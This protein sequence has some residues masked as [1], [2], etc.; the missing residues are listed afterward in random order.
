VAQEVVKHAFLENPQLVALILTKDVKK[1]NSWMAFLMSCQLKP[2]T[3]GRR[4]EG[5]KERLKEMDTHLRQKLLADEFFVEDEKTKAPHRRARVQ[6]LEEIEGWLQE[7]KPTSPYTALH[8]QRYTKCYRERRLKQ[9]N[10]A[11]GTV[12]DLLGDTVFRTYSEKQQF[13]VCVV[14]EAHLVSELKILRFLAST[15]KLLLVGKD[16]TLVEALD[17]QEEDHNIHPKSLLQRYV[18][19]PAAF[20]F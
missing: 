19:R 5:V 15:R 2:F 13:D 17:V 20:H 7:N 9:T 8:L 18:M 16:V 3:V 12:D 4:F 14:D 1:V 6:V 10:V 11:L